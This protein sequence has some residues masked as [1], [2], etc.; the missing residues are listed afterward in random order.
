MAELDPLAEARERAKEV[1]RA[2][3]WPSLKVA[4]YAI[5]IAV[6]AASTLST[7]LVQGKLTTPGGAFWIVATVAFIAGPVVF[8]ANEWHRLRE[9][10]AALRALYDA[11]KQYESLIQVARD[12]R[13]QAKLQATAM[14][15]EIVGLRNATIV[16]V[17]AIKAATG[18]NRGNG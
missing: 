13:D 11:Q 6:A 18:G 15:A 17:E 10:A 4:A 14:A 16:I 3:F 9:R 2:D 1:L 8:L 7:F 5:V 12:E